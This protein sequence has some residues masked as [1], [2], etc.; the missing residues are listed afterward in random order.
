MAEPR[1]A[2]AP[3]AQLSDRDARGAVRLRVGRKRRPRTVPDVARARHDGRDA[4]GAAVAWF[5]LYHRI[6]EPA[7]T[8]MADHL[9][10]YIDAAAQALG[11]PVQPEWKP[12]V[13]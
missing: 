12:A 3:P 4:G 2:A 6:D 9:D 1:L 13:G 5:L 11:I 7:G 8:L 10:A